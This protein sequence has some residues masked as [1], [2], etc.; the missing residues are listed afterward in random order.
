MHGPLNVK[1]THT[2]ART[3]SILSFFAEFI[4]FFLAWFQPFANYLN[5]T[6]IFDSKWDA[7]VYKNYTGSMFNVMFPSLTNLV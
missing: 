5:M 3:H 2:Q 4:F 7:C 1:Y 6:D